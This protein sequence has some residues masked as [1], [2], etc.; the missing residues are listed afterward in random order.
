MSTCP[1]PTIPGT[2]I[3][4]ECECPAP[5]T[6][7]CDDWYTSCRNPLYALDHA[8][9]CGLLTVTEL[10]LEPESLPI[11]VGRSGKVKVVALFSDGRTADVTGEASIG[12]SDASISRHLG[13]GVMDGLDVGTTGVTATWK[14]KLATGSVVVFDNACVASQ[15]WDVVVVADDGYILISHERATAWGG[16]R[17]AR[18]RAYA[19][20]DYTQM[21]FNFSLSLDLFD[22]GLFVL[23]VGWTTGTPTGVGG[24]RTG[25]DRIWNGAQWSDSIGPV[26]YVR[27]NPAAGNI[28][29]A[30]MDAY[31]IILTGRPDARKIVVLFSTG[32][33][34]G[35]S[36]GIAGAAQAIKN[37]GIEL[38]VV[39]P[40]T[41]NDTH[42]RSGCNPLVTA[43]SVLQ[44]AASSPCLFVDGLMGSPAGIPS[45]LM[46]VVC[47]GCSSS[48]QGIG[49]LSL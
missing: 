6:I 37:A 36:S 18:R 12:T 9:D 7:N 23:G 35:C 25:R 14:G 15:P 24:T 41:V 3:Y 30:L 49:L 26:D 19:G 38:V 20:V 22:N 47:E 43:Y 28:G 48:G 39:T 11:A 8:D 34:T 33:E 46:R 4:S 45:Q 17:V 44:A 31:G 21:I 40:L 10:A 42:L 13:D 2:A 29:G 32:G 1:T 16:Y 27:I 5:G